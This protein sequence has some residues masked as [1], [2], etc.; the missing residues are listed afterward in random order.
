MA[1]TRNR[2]RTDQVEAPVPVPEFTE[3][4]TYQ[5]TDEAPAETPVETPA[6]PAFSLDMVQDSDT[7]IKRA[8]RD[9]KPNPLKG[10]VLAALDNTK[11]IP[12]A[13]Q[14]AADL[15]VGLI[16]RDQRDEKDAGNDYGVSVT[17]IT[18]DTGK[19]F[20]LFRAKAGARSRKYTSVDVRK[21]ALDQ[22]PPLPV[23]VGKTTNSKGKQIESSA[24]PRATRDAYKE[25]HNL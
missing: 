12:V 24:I 8:K 16:R 25:A 1:L 6:A 10:A 18:D 17:V 5:D 19:M 7:D 22:S 9:A 15:A 21:W 2:S 3:Q 13:N 4:V 14:E 23:A 20:V 11:R